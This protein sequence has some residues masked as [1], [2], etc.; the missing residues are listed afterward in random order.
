MANPTLIQISDIVWLKNDTSGLFDIMGIV[1]DIRRNPIGFNMYDIRDFDGRLYRNKTRPNFSSTPDKSMTVIDIGKM[2]DD[3]MDIDIATITCNSPV[4]SS[5]NT[6]M[7]HAISSTTTS[8]ATT[9]NPDI[10]TGTDSRPTKMTIQPRL[11]LGLGTKK[12]FKNV[13]DQTIDALAS[14]TTAKTTNYQTQWTIRMLR[15]K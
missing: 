11:D 6:S 1:E 13:D 10:V 15:D 9:D 12:R 8:T 3:D 2:L 4:T 14:C 7:I 5:V